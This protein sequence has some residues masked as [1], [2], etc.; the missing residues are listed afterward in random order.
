MIFRGEELI[1]NDSGDESPAF[2]LEAGV[3]FQ[4]STCVILKVGGSGTVFP[5]ST[6][7]FPCHYNST[8][9]RSSQNI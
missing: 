7:V 6:S 5:R 2:Y 8:I 9:G 4:A 3:N 1:C